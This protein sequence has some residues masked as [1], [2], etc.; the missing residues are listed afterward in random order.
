MRLWARLFAGAALGVILGIGAAIW[1]VRAG[2][3]GMESAIGPWVTGKDFGTAAATPYTRA[4]VALRGLLALP[5]REARYYTAASDDAGRPLDGHCRYRIT[6]GALAAKWWSLTLYDP[7]G[8][9]VPNRPGVYSVGSVGLSPAAQAA[10]TVNVSPD[11]QAGH[12]LPSG[13]AERFELTLRVYLPADGGR[14][15][16]ARHNL[17]HIE[18]GSCA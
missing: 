13:G 9:L 11:Q 16:L 15:D 10:W 17:P 5:A 1:S 7:A 8:Y 3:L 14:G 4:I 12:W 18:R 2:T 6:G